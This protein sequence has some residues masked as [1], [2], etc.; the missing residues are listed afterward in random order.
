LEEHDDLRRPEL[1]SQDGYEILRAALWGLGGTD[2]PTPEEYLRVA[3]MGGRYT[4]ARRYLLGERMRVLG[5]PT[6]ERVRAT[7]GF[8]LSQRPKIR[9]PTWGRAGE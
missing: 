9:P 1:V 7:L 8:K 3:R 6:W 2:N 4:Q 5:N